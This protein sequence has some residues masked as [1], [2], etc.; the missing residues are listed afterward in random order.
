M[1]GILLM[2]KTGHDGEPAIPNNLCE[3]AMRHLR[4]HMTW[5][6][7]ALEIVS[8]PSSILT[9]QWEMDHLDDL[10][11][12]RDYFTSYVYIYIYI[13]KYIYKYIYTYMYI[14]IYVYI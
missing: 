10:P 7:F 13:S 2:P 6:G 8:L 1:T 4:L 11:I 9:Q 12:K 14:Y 5:R 3:S